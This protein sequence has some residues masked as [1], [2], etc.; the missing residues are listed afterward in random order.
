MD[1]DAEQKYDP[2]SFL[3]LNQ[4]SKQAKDFIG[5]L[6]AADQ[7]F[8]ADL[9]TI[10]NPFDFNDREKH[11][12]ELLMLGSAAIC[13]A[14]SSKERKRLGESFIRQL[15]QMTCRRGR[16]DSISISRR[17]TKESKECIRTFFLSQAPQSVVEAL[18]EKFANLGLLSVRDS[19]LMTPSLAGN[20]PADWLEFLK[21]SCTEDAASFLA[22]LTASDGPPTN[23]E[24]DLPVFLDEE[25]LAAPIRYKH[26]DDLDVPHL[27]PDDMFEND[28]HA[29]VSAVQPPPVMTQTTRPQKNARQLIPDTP[30]LDAHPQE[31]ALR[32]LLTQDKKPGDQ[33]AADL[34]ARPLY[35]LTKRRVSNLP[36]ARSSSR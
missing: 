21:I 34:T 1:D 18:P 17:W 36:H 13:R 23:D 6:S 28:D 2:T 30:P 29:I 31:A 20:I 5:D 25:M 15:R 12:T 10:C 8:E 22:T 26:D 7:D 32:R 24:S 4:L 33:V 19:R 3:R 14:E 35:I 16:T 9:G 11:L 27:L